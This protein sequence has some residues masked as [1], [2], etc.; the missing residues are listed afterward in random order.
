MCLKDNCVKREKCKKC[1]STDVR[2][3]G[4]LFGF[5]LPFT[6][7]T[8][9]FRSDDGD[10]HVRKG[11]DGCY[12]HD[13]VAFR[14]ESADL[15]HEYL[16]EKENCHINMTKKMFWDKVRKYIRDGIPVEKVSKIVEKIKKRQ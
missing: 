10:G 7:D 2:Y 12:F 9:S 6:K 13:P 1:K 16:K 14:S 5:P 4:R 11:C 8:Y 15:V 3:D